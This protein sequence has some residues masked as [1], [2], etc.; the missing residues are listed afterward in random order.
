MAD[1]FLSRAKGLL[2]RSDL[3]QGCGLV[4]THCNSIHMFF[5]KFS[6]DVMFIDASGVVVGVVNAIK[7]GA[8]SPIFWRADKAIELPVG[9]IEKTK[10]K[11]GDIVEIK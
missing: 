3:A 1:T 6:I 7:P 11:T 8:L 4:I 5:M 10:T 9:T 2:G